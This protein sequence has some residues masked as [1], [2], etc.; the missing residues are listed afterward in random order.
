MKSKENLFAF[1]TKG[2]EEITINFYTEGI[3]SL[4]I[5]VGDGYLF[6]SSVEL[7]TTRFKDAQKLLKVIDSLDAQ[8]LPEL[9][10]Q[11]RAKKYFVGGFTDKYYQENGQYISELV[12]ENDCYFKNGGLYVKLFQIY[13]NDSL[14]TV[15]P[16]KTEKEARKRFA[17]ENHLDDSYTFLDPVEVRC[18]SIEGMLSCT[19]QG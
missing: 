11:L 3:C 18:S 14:Y 4:R 12:S 9:L 15:I 2:S 17:Q 10:E 19:L 5:F 7:H 8:T 16:A 6:Y 1:L 13:C